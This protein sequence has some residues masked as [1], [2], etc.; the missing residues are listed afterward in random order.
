MITHSNTYHIFKK[1][2]HAFPEFA[3]VLLYVYRDIETKTFT[4]KKA[5]YF[6]QFQLIP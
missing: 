2:L 6:L 5:Y 1:V 4:F 3:K